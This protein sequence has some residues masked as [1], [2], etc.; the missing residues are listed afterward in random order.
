MLLFH[1][2]P[3]PHTLTRSLPVSFAALIILGCQTTPQSV[4]DKEGNDLFK[5]ESDRAGLL[6]Y[7]LDI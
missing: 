4:T 7:M 2:S 6:L 1:C 3:P 5:T